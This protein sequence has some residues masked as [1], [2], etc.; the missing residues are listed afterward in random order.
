[1]QTQDWFRTRKERDYLLSESKH[2]I[3]IGE[4]RL[5]NMTWPRPCN[6]SNECWKLHENS[7]PVFGD[8]VLTEISTCLANSECSVNMF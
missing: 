7:H 4:R 1:M 8:F 6:Y 5:K 3:F 2:L